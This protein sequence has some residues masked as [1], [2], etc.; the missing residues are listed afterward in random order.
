MP[1]TSSSPKRRPPRSRIARFLRC[2]TVE[3]AS[4]DGAAIVEF[5]TFAEAKAWYAS[6]PYQ[7]ASRDRYLGGDFRLP[8]PN[9]WLVETI[10]QRPTSTRNSLR[11]WCDAR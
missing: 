11:S 3:G 2:E 6:E 4:A 9:R 7:R 8:A 5:P 10:Q 1:A